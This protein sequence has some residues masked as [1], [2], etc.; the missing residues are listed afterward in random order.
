MWNTLQHGEVCRRRGHYRVVTHAETNAALVQIEVVA[1]QRAQLPDQKHLIRERCL[2]AQTRVI[3]V[4]RRVVF[5]DGVLDE[6][7]GIRDQI[8]DHQERRLFAADG[9]LL[10]AYRWVQSKVHRARFSSTRSARP[11]S[12]D[13]RIPGARASWRQSE[14]SPRGNRRDT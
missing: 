1:Q 4:W 10:D 7:V 5:G 12:T 14:Q 13:S 9:E 11:Y 6:F 2:G 3:T 8:V